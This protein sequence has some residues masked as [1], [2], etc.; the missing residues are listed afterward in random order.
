ME[1]VM[2]AYL[3]LFALGA[4]VS[5]E[6]EPPVAPQNP[7][8]QSSE[9][10]AP[11]ESASADAMPAPAPGASPPVATTQ[12]ATSSDGGALSVTDAATAAPVPSA[13]VSHGNIV[14]SVSTQPVSLRGQA[15]VYLED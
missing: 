11:A 2:K 12:V 1:I 15:V 3:T 4:L 13:T 5:C 14:G 6:G 7:I 8:G 10:A 9:V